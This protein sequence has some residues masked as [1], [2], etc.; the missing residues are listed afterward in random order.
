MKI[1]LN[2]ENQA[3]Y[4]AGEIALGVRDDT[5]SKVR[6]VNRDGFMCLVITTNTPYTHV[7]PYTQETTALNL[8]AEETKNAI[9]EGTIKV[10]RSSGFKQ[11]DKVLTREEQIKQGV[12]REIEVCASLKEGA[13]D[14]DNPSSYDWFILNDNSNRYIKIA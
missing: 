14:K 5:Y 1:L 7:N 9:K 8:T 10:Y 4:D 12:A 11:G 13:K 3:L 6:V 2:E